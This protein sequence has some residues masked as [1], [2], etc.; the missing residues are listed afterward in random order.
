M[1]HSLSVAIPLKE[2]PKFPCCRCKS[3]I[4]QPLSNLFLRRDRVQPS[5]DVGNV[6]E[7]HCRHEDEGVECVV[8]GARHQ[9]AS[10]GRQGGEGEQDLGR[11]SVVS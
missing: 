3:G 1:L 5:G 4:T 7:V 6:E 8:D 10:G 9:G 11:Y 2:G